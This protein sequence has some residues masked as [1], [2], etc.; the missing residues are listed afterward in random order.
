MDLKIQYNKENKGELPFHSLPIYRLFCE[1]IG[2]QMEWNQQEKILHLAPRLQG[3]KVYLIP[4]KLNDT[5]TAMLENTKAFLKQTDV[6]VEVL[7]A[8]SSP[9]DDGEIII[10]L[11]LNSS[12]NLSSFLEF[13]ILH[14]HGTKAKTWAEAFG[15]E[16]KKSGYAAQIKEDT[17][18]SSVPFLEIS[19]KL[20]EKMKI[21]EKLG[22]RV[23]L[24]L[25]SG[26]FR[27]FTKENPFL[28]LPFLPPESVKFL[29]PTKSKSSSESAPVV[30][31]QESNNP[32]DTKNKDNKTPKIIPLPP[33][34][35][36][37][38]FDYQV[39]FPT[40]K[41]DDYLVLGNMY[42]KNSGMGVLTN[43][44]IC[45]QV[46]PSDRIQLKGQIIPPK[47]T[48]TVG[49]Q[50]FSGD[51]AVGWRYV[52]ENWREKVKEKGEY[53]ICSIQPIHIM[54]GETITFP[55]FQFSIPNDSSRDIKIQGSVHYKD[56]NLEF[57]SSNRILLSFA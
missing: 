2:F 39:V 25:A 1:Q 18:K 52:D 12:S 43:P 5:H 49:I 41:D 45:I 28:L 29:L 6:E 34:R 8:K 47:M 53:W 16:C 17:K 22:E 31:K 30:T 4:V 44:H 55:N 20:P 10:K 13:T 23:S 40:S 37:V 11:K 57:P 50:S 26:L 14:S 51:S 38:C 24:I 21:D 46:S 9:P 3:K 19:M 33:F 42:L 35:M 7:P 27:G 36:E 56:F 48:D 54:P 15:K 32:I